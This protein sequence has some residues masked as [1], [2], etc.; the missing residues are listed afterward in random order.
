MSKVTV[1][2]K[3]VARK[4]AVEM[5]KAEVLKMVEPTRLEPGC[6]EYRLHQDNENPAVF[7][8]YENWENLSCLKQHLNSTHYQSYVAAVGDLLS[9]KIVN[10]MTE[11]A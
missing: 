9:E 1:V 8:F 4:D 6:I 2:A 3:L 10:K 11:I 5:V 7:L